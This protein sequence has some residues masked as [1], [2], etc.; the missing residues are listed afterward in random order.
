MQN[1]LALED[2]K[3]NFPAELAKLRQLVSRMESYEIELWWQDEARYRSEKQD[4]HGV[5]RA[6][7]PGPGRRTTSAPNGSISSAPS[8][9]PKAK[10]RGL[11]MP[12]CNSQAMNAH[13]AEAI[14][15]R[16][17]QRPCG[18]SRSIRPAGTPDKKLVVPDN[19]GPDAIAA[20]RAGA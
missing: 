14:H 7:A 10:R 9:R 15:G 16:R 17:C 4:R 18:G 1:E 3:K 11:I 6:G 20:A 13:L 8:A 19:I 5:G 2:F 12:Y